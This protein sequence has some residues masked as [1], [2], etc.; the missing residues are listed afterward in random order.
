M[1]NSKNNSVGDSKDPLAGFN[2]DDWT[3]PSNDVSGWTCDFDFSL[4]NP[5]EQSPPARGRLFSIPSNSSDEPVPQ[6]ESAPNDATQTEDLSW[7]DNL[8]P[9]PAERTR[10][11]SVPDVSS[12][13]YPE[14]NAQSSS[15]PY[16]NAPQQDALGAS[17][18]FTQT[19]FG[20]VS[21]TGL[22]TADLSLFNLPLDLDSS[23]AIAPIANNT[24]TPPKPMAAARRR[25][26][27]VRGEVRRKSSNSTNSDEYT[28]AL[29]T[30]TYKRE[31]PK[32]DPDHPWHRINTTTMGLTKRSGKINQYKAKEM[33]KQGLRNTFSA[34][35]S[36]N[37]RFDYY[38]HGELSKLEYSA[39]EIKE[40]IYHHPSS[41][42]SKL[43]LWIQKTPADS[44]KRYHTPT[45]PKCRFSDCPSRLAG[46]NGTIWS[47]HMRVAV[48]ERSIKYKEKADPF[49]MAAYFHLYCFEKFLDL[50]HICT[51]SN[52]EVL[53]DTRQLANEPNMKWGASLTAAKEG[54]VAQRFIE[55]CRKGRSRIRDFDNYPRPHA[56]APGADWP[57]KLTLSYRMQVVKEGDRARSSKESLSKR[58]QRATQINVNLGDLDMAC[59]AKAAMRKPQ[60]TPQPRQSRRTRK[61][62]ASSWISEV[63]SDYVS[64]ADEDDGLPERMRKKPRR[65]HNNNAPSGAEPA[66]SLSLHQSAA[67]A[68][69]GADADALMLQPALDQQY[70]WPQY[71]SGTAAAATGLANALT[72]S[73]PEI[74]TT[75]DFDPAIFVDPAPDSFH[76]Q[77][78]VPDYPPDIF[79][80]ARTAAAPT[81]TTTT[82]TTAPSSS[83]F[84]PPK[85]PRHREVSVPNSFPLGA[86]FALAKPAKR[87]RDGDDE[88]DDLQRP[89]SKRRRFSSATADVMHPLSAISANVEVSPKSRVAST[90]TVETPRRR[91]VRLGSKSS[92]TSQRRRSSRLNET[93]GDG[94]GSWDSFGNLLGS[95]SDETGRRR[96][97]RLSKSTSGSNS[98][99]SLGSLFGA[100]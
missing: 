75:L 56:I 81:T 46:L 7:L 1:T 34:W 59:S 63:D 78:S 97:S 53:A 13:A 66:I 41:Q 94:R 52:V 74:S 38:E 49:Y 93:N 4:I 16:F 45:L 5:S 19:N 92:S 26:S 83:P 55:S 18:G 48:D 23:E 100:E 72:T 98:F 96:S 90:V 3:M 2:L 9:A 62:R 6:A 25:S 87:V 29:P 43:L 8:A 61:R 54:I 11:Y 71:T 73:A 33:Y 24:V 37:Y 31:K 36:P 80:T 17:S 76:Q 64:E 95:S 85:T 10:L 67:Q 32:Y 60:P 40:F 12:T 84:R 14:P 57:Y 20:D 22:D 35:R 68:Y 44:G 88:N 58:P 70:A 89:S 42:D 28:A 77:Q 91:S 79:G 50:P 15:N 30:R 86:D 51:L 69:S 39:D 82:T 27:S 47:G 21:S 99:G 65:G